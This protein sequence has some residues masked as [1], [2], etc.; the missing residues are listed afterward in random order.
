MAS[1]WVRVCCA[2]CRIASAVLVAA[3]AF[4]SAGAENGKTLPDV[5]RFK[6]FASS[7]AT[8][9]AEVL[10]YHGVKK[11]LPNVVLIGGLEGRIYRCDCGKGI[12]LWDIAAGTRLWAAAEGL[13]VTAEALVLRSL[14]SAAKSAEQA[15]ASAGG[16]A[17]TPDRLLD[18]ADPPSLKLRRTGERRSS[19]ASGGQ[20]KGSAESNAN[21]D[22]ATGKTPS[23]GA[24]G[25]SP[26]PVGVP[27]PD[28]DRLDFV[29]YR[30][31]IDAKQP[32]VLTYS[33]DVASDKGMEASFRS[34]ERVSVVGIGYDESGSE[35]H[36]IALLPQDWAKEKR[37]ERLMAVPGV[38]KGEREGLLVIP[39]EVSTGNLIATFITVQAD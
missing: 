4:S 30:Q 26:Q 10:S 23:A 37:F 25:P 3:I 16:G 17:A 27:H 28:G 36:V 21:K 12:D 24:P 13:K 11:G 2:W 39:W 20:G 8:A 22:Q 6:L 19:S 15:A 33:L 32:A 18:F 38:K 5:P 29:R 34:Q 9:A 31:A 14:L 7:H 35:R 1:L